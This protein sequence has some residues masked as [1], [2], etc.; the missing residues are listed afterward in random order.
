MTTIKVKSSKEYSIIVGNN[1]LDNIG[2]HLKELKPSCKVMVITDDNVDK[3]YFET[4]NTSLTQA[5]YSVEKF[6]FTHGENSKTLATYCEILQEIAEQSFTRT[7]IIVALGGGIVGDIAGFVA[8]SYMRGIDF[9][10]VPTTILAQIDSSVGGKTGVNLPNGKNLVGAFCQPILVL[11]DIETTKTLPKEIFDDGMGEMSKYGVLI[12]EEFAKLIEKNNL[13]ENLFELIVKSIE[14]KRDIVEVDEFE[15]GERKLLNLGHTIAHGIEKLSN[16]EISHGK[17]VG[18]GMKVITC[19]S[20]KNN[21][22][23][24]T[25]YDRIIEIIRLCNQTED[26][27][28]SIAELVETFSLDKKCSGDTITLVLTEGIGKGVLKKV[29]IEKVLEILS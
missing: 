25:E 10:Q 12:G 9:V 8:S 21:M 11:C 28:F 27:P 2:T 20:Y 17:A 13:K 19:A 1:I 3:L 22:I 4:V 26:N 18:M 7:D 15:K 23:S 24:K 5:G 6:I 14:Y 29:K 16:F